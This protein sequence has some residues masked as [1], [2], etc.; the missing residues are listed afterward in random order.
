MSIT[1]ERFE[2]GLSYQAYKEAMTRNRDRV[3][4][5]VLCATSRDFQ[6]SVRDWASFAVTPWLSLA[7]RVVPKVQTA[8]DD[9]LMRT[10]VGGKT[11]WKS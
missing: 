9:T 5:M 2:S 11:V 10:I 3:E 1:R 7:A 6:G 8:A 4:A